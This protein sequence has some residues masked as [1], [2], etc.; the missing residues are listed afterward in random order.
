M[1]ALVRGIVRRLGLWSPLL[2]AALLARMLRLGVLPGAPGAA[3]AEAGGAAEAQRGAGQQAAV[4]VGEEGPAQERGLRD[5]AELRQAARAPIL[6]Y[7]V[8]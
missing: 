2:G 5:L 8:S 7:S 1:G 4:A 6:C 3:A